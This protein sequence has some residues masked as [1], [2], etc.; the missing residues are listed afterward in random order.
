PGRW[1]AAGSRS[2][3]F[4]EW[5]SAAGR[6]GF[7]YR[8]IPRPDGQDASGAGEGPQV[9]PGSDLGGPDRRAEGAFNKLVGKPFDPA[10]LR[11]APGNPP[12]GARPGATS[13]GTSRQRARRNA[14]P[15][16]DGDEPQ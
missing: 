9:R 4:P 12:G 14:A 10:Q 7:Q 15:P 2:G 3:R 13:G 1:P 11:P 8:R 6:P 5:R 16:P